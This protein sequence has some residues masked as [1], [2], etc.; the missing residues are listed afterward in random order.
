MASFRWQTLLI[1]LSGVP[2]AGAII[3]SLTTGR[4]VQTSP[5][6]QLTGRD[7]NL[8]AFYLCVTGK[9]IS[10][11]FIYV[12]HAADDWMFSTAE[13]SMGQLSQRQSSLTD[14]TDDK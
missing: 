4:S 2:L 13:G 10:C 11:D 8:D 9:A 14:E 6:F 12:P 1:L 7:N 3:L 5:I